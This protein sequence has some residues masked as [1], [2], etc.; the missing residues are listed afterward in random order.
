[1][2]RFVDKLLRRDKGIQE[3]LPHETG[4]RRVIG[5]KRKKQ[6]VKDQ[7]A[8]QSDPAWSFRL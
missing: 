2:D 4:T 7:S 6:K 3:P 1:M 5:L 8:P